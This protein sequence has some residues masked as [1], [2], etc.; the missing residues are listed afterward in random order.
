MPEDNGLENKIYKSKSNE[1]L[2]K[3]NKHHTRKNSGY[4][5]KK[6]DQKCIPIVNFKV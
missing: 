3:K 5:R 2:D 6:L 1:N 4:N